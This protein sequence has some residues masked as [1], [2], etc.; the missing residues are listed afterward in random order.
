MK[1]NRSFMTFLVSA[2]LVAVLAFGAVRAQKLPGLGTVKKKLNTF[3]LSRL[4]EAEP[5]IS[6]SL[7]DA[8]ME[9]PFLDDFNPPEPSPM[10]LLPRASNGN[11]ILVGP[12]VFELAAASYCL[13]A[14]TYAPARGEGYLYA[15]LK[16][17]RAEIVRHILE[18]SVF[19]SDVPQKDIQYLLWGI[20]ARTKFTKMARSIQLAAAKLLTPAEIAALSG[21]SLDAVP[22]AVLE[23][24]MGEA[25]LPAPLRDVLRAESRIRDMMTRADTSYADLERVAVLAGTPLPGERSRDVA[26]GRWSFHPGGYFIRYFPRGYALTNIQVNVPGPFRVERDSAGRITA[27]SDDVGSRIIFLYSPSGV[28][29]TSSGS[30]SLRAHAFKSIAYSGVHPWRLDQKVEGSWAGAG[31]T[32]AGFE[33]GAAFPADVSSPFPD[34]KARLDRAG[35]LKNRLSGLAKVS[36]NP[37][38]FLPPDRESLCLEIGSLCDGLREVLATGGALDK[39]PGSDAYAF[40]KRV[41][42]SA[43]TGMAAPAAAAA[44]P[45]G[46]HPRPGEELRFFGADPTF[47]KPGRGP[48]PGPFIGD[49]S[50]ADS[51]GGLGG[52]EASFDAA[53]PGNTARQRLGESARPA[54]PGCMA[55]IGNMS[56]DVK[57]NGQPATERMFSG[58]ELQGGN[59][60]TGRKGRVQLVLPDGSTLRMGSNSKMSFPQD[61]CQQAKESLERQAVFK[62][63]VDDGFLF[64][65]PG[66][67]TPFEIVGSAPGAGVRGD[68][69]RLVQGPNDRIFLA[70]LDGPSQE[71]FTE[72]A[73]EGEY[74]DLKP[75]DT[76]LA[77]R[78]TVVFIGYKPGAFF[79]VRVARGTVAVDDPKGSTVTLKEG[80]HVFVRLTPWPAPDGRG[81]LSVRTIRGK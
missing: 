50:Q 79:Y 9:V 80:E 60:T 19:R 24:A 20:V 10:T 12:G 39:R 28:T 69:Q 36:G 34:S 31:W 7:D 22:D 53:M 52:S 15:P 30:G 72:A 13:Q 33:A 44:G 1:R 37:A 55:I 68:L 76:E 56:G 77:A 45:A 46:Y 51:G 58:S 64:F 38:G 42:Q 62:A 67:A 6:T 59:V 43:M 57:I 54:D 66:L 4:L 11:F 75:S 5:P 47:E 78:K 16:G 35:E 40:L 25:S 14:G 8:V 48:S 27:I 21:A 29:T 71:A 73:I 74:N 17:K 18:N 41:W 23:R 70:S 65:L 32:L 26:S 49:A 2:S 3:S 63:L 61:L 81:G